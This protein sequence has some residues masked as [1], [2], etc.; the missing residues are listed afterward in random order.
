VHVSLLTWNLDGQHAHSWGS[1]C[2]SRLSNAEQLLSLG[3]I[4]IYKQ[5][6]IASA[7]L[8]TAQQNTNNNAISCRVIDTC[9]HLQER[10]GDSIRDLLR[11]NTNTAMGVGK[12]PWPTCACLSETIALPLYPK[13]RNHTIHGHKSKASYGSMM[14]RPGPASPAPRPCWSAKA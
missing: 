10:A 2:E 1:R 3:I 4:S 9:F 8:M 7:K 12:L 13:H 6:P 14:P 11:L 5:G